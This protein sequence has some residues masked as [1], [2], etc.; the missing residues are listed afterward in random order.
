MTYSALPETA[1]LARAWVWLC[2]GDARI[3]CAR[4][5]DA[6]HHLELARTKTRALPRRELDVIH[7]LLLGRAQ[8]VVAADVV[9]SCS[10][11]TAAAMSA[12]KRMGLVCRPNNVPMIAVMMARAGASNLLAPCAIAGF[13]ESVG[14]TVSFS[15][16]RPDVWLSQVLTRTERKVVQLRIEG[17]SHED[18]ASLCMVSKRTVANQIASAYRKLGVSSRLEL[19]NRILDATQGPSPLPLGS[20]PD[21][22]TLELAALHPPLEGYGLT[23]G[24]HEAGLHVSHAEH[25]LHW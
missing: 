16:A 13:A 12:L 23:P 11:V 20:P 25:R 1:L 14:Q 3:V 19:L 24:H 2:A 17:H 10:T 9:R 8:K 18:V 22:I 15:V 5:D 7:P 21:G 6:R 4:S